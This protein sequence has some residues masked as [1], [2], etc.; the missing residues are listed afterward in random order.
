MGA[1]VEVG[2]LGVVLTGREW[3]GPELQYVIC[4]LTVLL[5]TGFRGEVGS[6]DDSIL[7]PELPG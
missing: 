4:R 2:L 5:A 3:I 1:G 6:R 7:N